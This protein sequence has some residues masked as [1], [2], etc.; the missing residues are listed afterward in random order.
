MDFT[1]I[2][3]GCSPNARPATNLQHAAGR[4]GERGAPTVV[5]RVGV[6]HQ[7]A[8]RVVPTTEIQHDQTPARR[9]LRLGEF[10]EECRRREPDGE[11]RN[12][13]T[14]ELSTCELHRLAP[15]YTN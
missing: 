14:H 4:H 3:F 13:A 8:Q 5:R 12:A 7:R 1:P 10:A 11:R 9:A 6:G 2:K 15:S